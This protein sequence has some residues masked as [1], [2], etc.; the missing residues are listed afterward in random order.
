MLFSEIGTALNFMGG[1]YGREFYCIYCVALLIGATVPSFA[2]EDPKQ[3]FTCTAKTPLKIFTCYFQPK[4]PGLRKNRPDCND[5]NRN[6]R[7]NELCAATNSQ[8]WALRGFHECT[9]AEIMLAL[10][11]RPGGRLVVSSP[12]PFALGSAYGLYHLWYGNRIYRRSFGEL[13]RLFEPVG[14]EE[15][16]ARRAGMLWHVAAEHRA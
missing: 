6:T 15:V 9:D 11:L 16:G 2:E 3:T 1:R 4:E 12:G 7:R 14:L 10:H 8:R 13:R 5:R